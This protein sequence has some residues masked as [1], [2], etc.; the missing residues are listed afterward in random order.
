MN[1]PTMIDRVIAFLYSH[2]LLAFNFW[3]KQRLTL[4]IRTGS[5]IKTHYSLTFHEKV[6]PDRSLKIHSTDL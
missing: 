3:L 6:N 1:F 2:L 5:Y 4:I